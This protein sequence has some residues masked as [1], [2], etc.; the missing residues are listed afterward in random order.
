MR[1]LPLDKADDSLSES[2]LVNVQVIRS[3]L[4]AVPTESGKDDQVEYP[5]EPRE[6][7]ELV[8][9]ACLKRYPA[10][11]GR[12]E[13]LLDFWTEF[14]AN[15]ELTSVEGHPLVPHGEPFQFDAGNKLSEVL[16]FILNI[17]DNEY[18]DWFGRNLPRQAT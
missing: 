6:K 12:N 9:S 7:C 11:Q 8:E 13:R 2:E 16:N 1:F 14:E 5:T 17:Q 10:E 18:N 3:N 4:K 15:Y